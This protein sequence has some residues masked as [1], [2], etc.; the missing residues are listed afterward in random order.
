MKWLAKRLD[1]LSNLGYYVKS[2][3]NKKGYVRLDSNE[4]LVLGKNFALE[5]SAKALKEVDLRIYPSEEYEANLYR[6]L[7]KYLDIDQKYIAGVS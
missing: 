2:N 5:V 6:Q 7:E 3:N 1:Y 4:N